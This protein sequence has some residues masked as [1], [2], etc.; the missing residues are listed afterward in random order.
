MN[1]KVEKSEEL[2][3]G[4][5]PFSVDG[6][7]YL[8]GGLG[9]RWDGRY[10]DAECPFSH[11][12]GT[13]HVHLSKGECSCGIYMQNPLVYTGREVMA[14]CVGWGICIVADH[15]Y[16]VEHCRIDRIFV[17]EGTP[18]NVCAQLGLRYGVPV[19]SAKPALV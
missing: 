15:G 1:M 4:Y 17:P 8:Y 16:R 2:V 10:L 3:I 14:E 18:E 6:Q 9:H 19:T 11:R 7:G 12:A 13:A 5:R